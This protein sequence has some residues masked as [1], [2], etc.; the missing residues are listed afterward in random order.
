[1][2]DDRCRRKKSNG[3][4]E[5]R[6]DVACGCLTRVPADQLVGEG[7]SGHETPTC[8]VMDWGGV[9]RRVYEGNSTMGVWGTTVH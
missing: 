8:S 3:L 5:G 1:M 4:A 6:R 2:G 7:E 9:V